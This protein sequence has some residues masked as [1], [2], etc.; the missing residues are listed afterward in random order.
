MV[1]PRAVVNF[2][3]LSFALTSVPV[4]AQ[5]PQETISG[6]PQAWREVLDAYQRLDGLKTY[7]IRKTSTPAPPDLPVIAS[8]YGRDPHRVEVVK[9]DRFRVII[10]PGTEYVVVGSSITARTRVASGSTP[11]LCL[12]ST[13]VARI[14]TGGGES[15]FPVGQFL[16]LNYAGLQPLEPQLLGLVRGA[17]ASL[18]RR[19]TITRPPD[20]TVGGGLA[21]VYEYEVTLTSGQGLRT[22]LRERLYVIEPGVPGRTQI[23]GN[24]FIPVA[25]FDYSDY[26]VSI[27][28]EPPRC[29][30]T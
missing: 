2:L 25:T 12:P 23:L 16:T 30:R 1:M 19:I 7:R 9:P 29:L 27:A 8:A 22:R 15:E 28:I 3:I 14:P 6:D 21:R 20:E 10:P 5:S 13:Y 26:D 18:P 17:L 24:A 11:W 4:S